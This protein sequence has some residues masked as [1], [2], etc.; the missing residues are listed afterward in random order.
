MLL[1]SPKNYHILQNFIMKLWNP[2]TEPTKSKELSRKKI[3]YSFGTRLSESQ[4]GFMIIFFTFSRNFAEN[5]VKF[6]Q[7]QEI[8]RKLSLWSDEVDPI[9]FSEPPTQVNFNNIQSKSKF[10]P[11]P[12]R[13]DGR[14][15]IWVIEKLQ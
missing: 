3:S 2:M 12:N 7:T 8:L 14:G 10:S 9:S 15:N 5:V 11:Q 6:C 13:F 4:E 1:S